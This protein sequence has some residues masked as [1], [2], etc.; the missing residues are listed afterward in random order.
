MIY[1]VL[2][3]EKKPNRITRTGAVFNTNWILFFL[4][5]ILLKYQLYIVFTY[6][7]ITLFKSVNRH[8]PSMVL[9]FESGTKHKL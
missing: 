5:I 8:K 4:S 9:G 6:D 1:D 3:N 2:K 7:K